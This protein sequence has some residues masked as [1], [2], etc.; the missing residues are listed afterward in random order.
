[1]ICERL[2]RHGRVTNAE[3]YRAHVEGKYQL[4]NDT[5]VTVSTNGYHA[6]ADQKAH[7]FV[8]TC[9][10]LKRENVATQQ[11]TEDTAVSWLAVE[12]DENSA[13]AEA[14]TTLPLAVSS[15]SDRTF[16]LINSWITSCVDGHEKCQMG[17]TH[18][19]LQHAGLVDDEGARLRARYSE[20]DGELP[21]RLFDVEFFEDH[22]ML[23]DS[24]SSRGKKMIYCIEPRL[25][26]DEAFQDRNRYLRQT[27]N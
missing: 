23:I 16:S 6:A 12:A 26:R 19:E 25:G 5:S 3:N 17:Y 15:L 11:L 8:F 7:Q 20:E 9:G 14:V 4:V 10:P 13:S 18:E 1:M 21:T 2:E 24:A 22:V 27:S